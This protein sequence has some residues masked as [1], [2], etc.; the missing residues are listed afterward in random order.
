MSNGNSTSSND[1]AAQP[2]NQQSL[3]SADVSSINSKLDAILTCVSAV[4]DELSDY[5]KSND[6]NINTINVR[7]DANDEKLAEL[8]R[9][10]AALESA[11]PN[12]TNIVKD[13][14]LLK[15]QQLKNNICF[16]GIP[17]KENENLHDIVKAIG[18]AIKVK[19]GPNDVISVHRT[20]PSQRSPGLIIV[21]LSSYEKKMEIMKAKRTKEKLFAS[22]LKMK[23]EPAN[24]MIFINHQMTPYYSTLFYKAKAAAVDGRLKN[25][26]IGGGCLCLRLTDNTQTVVKSCDELEAI[27]LAAQLQSSSSS[28]ESASDS[29]DPTQ[30]TGKK[31]TRKRKA[32]IVDPDSR[33]MENQQSVINRSN[34]KRKRNKKNLT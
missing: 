1:S 12:E 23:L 13:S 22:Q 29:G 21:K 2:Q 27:V 20:K 25:C 3:M 26:W 34:G 7:V 17:L 9:K 10:L 6:A 11:R 8:E 14:E 4:R 32:T 18:S 31:K 19:I 33:R 16:H 30:T 5:K 24:K 28:Y 15:Q